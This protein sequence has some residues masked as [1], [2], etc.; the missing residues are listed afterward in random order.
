MAKR[1]STVLSIAG[2]DSIGGAGIQADIKTCS[3]LG[4]YAMTALTALTAQNTFDVSSILPTSPDFILAQLQTILA[5]VTPDAIKIGMLPD[6]D[7]ALTV[8]EFLKT[9]ASDIPIVLDPVMVATA[10]A[11]LAKD[12]VADV[13]ISHLAPLATLITP[14]IPEARFFADCLAIPFSQDYSVEGLASDIA[15]R[16]NSN[17]LLKGGHLEDS[18]LL[19]DILASPNG[20]IHRFSHPKI[21]TP[22]THGTGCSLSSAIA[23]G[24]AKG[25]PLPEA[26]DT[27]ISWLHQAIF[28]GAPFHFGHGH[29][30]VCHLPHPR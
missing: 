21:D 24:L 30:P 20:S 26:C 27:A 17:L 5:D 2:S 3:A 9:H 19:T 11:S 1:Y 4:V 22:N 28:A 6:T 8:A 25:I 12:G 10:G 23:C 29:G 13:I 16:L 7:S 15:V 14:N 18:N